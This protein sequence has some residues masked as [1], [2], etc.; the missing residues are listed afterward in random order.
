MTPERYQKFKQ[1][2]FCY[3]YKLLL[4]DMLKALIFQKSHNQQP[5]H[6]HAI[7]ELQDE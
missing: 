6:R 1:Y 5:K 7:R 2:I 3:G 4:A